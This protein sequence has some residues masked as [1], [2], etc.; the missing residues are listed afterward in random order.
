MTRQHTTG[1][2]IAGL[3]AALSAYDAVLGFKILTNVFKYEK[4]YSQF[5]ANLMENSD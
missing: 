3:F 4:D 2:I 1:A 5:V